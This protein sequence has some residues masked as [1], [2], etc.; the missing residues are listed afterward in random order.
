MA[1]LVSHTA[2]QARTQETWFGPFFLRGN[3]GV[4]IFFVISGFL[5]YRPWAAASVNAE[6]APELGPYLRN[7]ALRI[8][9]AY[10]VA[11]TVLALWPGLPG[12][13]LGG[14]WRYYG[15]M[16]LYSSD[17]VLQ[18]IA[19]A[20]TLCVEVSYYLTLP[21]V[22]LALKRCSLGRQAVVLLL[23]AGLSAAF[24]T[25]ILLTTDV[26]NVAATLPGLIGWFCVGMLLALVAVA[27]PSGSPPRWRTVVQRRPERCWVAALILYLVVVYGSGLPPAP[28]FPPP[29]ATAATV[30]WEYFAYALVAGLVALPAVV[31]ADGTRLVGRILRGR[32]FASLGLISYGVFLWHDP[33]IYE[34]DAAG[35]QSWIPGAPF[36]GMTLATMIVATILGAASYV[37]V[38]RPALRLKRPW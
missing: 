27:R 28:R 22:A 17:T 38:E 19:P 30:A 6:P 36:I 3:V 21:L 7:R 29:D 20:W 32:L 8:V 16:Q 31:G 37:L 34:L 25:T 35:A 13:S 26:P 11:L 2:A 15:F 9:P 33:L 14:A 5:L 10:W 12:M 24:R 4:T 18:G 1:V 23:M